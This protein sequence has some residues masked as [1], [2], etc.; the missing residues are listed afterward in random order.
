MDR[1]ELNEIK[2]IAS[3]YAA[4]LYYL[5]HKK[6]VNGHGHKQHMSFARLNSSILYEQ[7]NS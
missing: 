7:I 1:N 5:F 4:K 3:R 2:N 6:N